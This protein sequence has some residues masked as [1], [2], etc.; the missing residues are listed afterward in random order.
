M[1]SHSHSKPWSW[2]SSLEPSLDPDAVGPGARL[3]GRGRV[4]CLLSAGEGHV[5]RGLGRGWLGL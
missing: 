2:G 1:E 3:L 4:S 5:L